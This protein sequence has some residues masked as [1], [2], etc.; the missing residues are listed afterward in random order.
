MFDTFRFKYQSAVAVEN[1][2]FPSA[3]HGYIR[4]TTTQGQIHGNATTQ[5]AQMKTIPIGI[6]T[7][8]RLC[9]T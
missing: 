5:M 4:P 8:V 1:Q 3:V 2:M 6:F 9:F 7:T